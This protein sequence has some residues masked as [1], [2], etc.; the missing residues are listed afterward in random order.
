MCVLQAIIIWEWYDAT[1]LHVC[2][3]KNPALSAI[4]NGWLWHNYFFVF[5]H[6]ARPCFALRRVTTAVIKFY[7]QSWLRNTKPAIVKH[8]QQQ[9]HKINWEDISL[10]TSIPHW[11]TRRVR[12]AIEIL[13]YNTT[14][15]H[16]IAGY[17]ST[18]SGTLSCRKHITKHCFTQ[19]RNQLNIKSLHSR[20][21]PIHKSSTLQ[22]SSHSPDEDGQHRLMLPQAF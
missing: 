4:T 21:Q 18:T 2:N 17:T 11:H 14:Q 1:L 16:K 3:C 19:V 13:Q 22:S 7:A 5:F 20:L 12:E 8:A 6:T 10:I 9:Q 15:F